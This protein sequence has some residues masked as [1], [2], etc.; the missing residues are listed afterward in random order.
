MQAELDCHI[1]GKSF[2][3]DVLYISLTH[4]ILLISIHF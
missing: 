2:Y 4:I 3:A 1:L